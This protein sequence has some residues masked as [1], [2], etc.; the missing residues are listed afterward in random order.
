[1]QCAYQ[2]RELKKPISRRLDAFGKL[3]WAGNARSEDRMEHVR[4]RS[5]TTVIIDLYPLKRAEERVVSDYEI[6][7]RDLKPRDDVSSSVDELFVHAKAMIAEVNSSCECHHPGEDAPSQLTAEHGIV[8]LTSDERTRME[9]MSGKSNFGISAF[10]VGYLGRD[11]HGLIVEDHAQNVKSRLGIWELEAS[12]LVHKY[13]QNIV[14]YG[15]HRQK[16][17]RRNRSPDAHAESFPRIPVTRHRKGRSVVIL[18]NPS[19]RRKPIHKKT[20]F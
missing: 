4:D 15:T 3:Q 16:R 5:L 7:K 17:G 12:R 19:A 18:A 11:I 1:M 6:F 20:S 2:I 13:A 9:A 8:L 14:C 10:K